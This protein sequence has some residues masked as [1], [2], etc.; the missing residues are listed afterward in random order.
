M[1]GRY[2]PPENAQ[3]SNSVQNGSPIIMPGSI[4]LWAQRYNIFVLTQEQRA[5]VVL[6]L[7]K[8]FDILLFRSDSSV[9]N[10]SINRL[11]IL[12]VFITS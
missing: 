11:Q 12:T 7:S 5:D 3:M 6:L 8:R 1:V 9:M 10:V 2:K 4:E